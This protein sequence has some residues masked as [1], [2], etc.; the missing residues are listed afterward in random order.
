MF[1]LNKSCFSK[2]DTN[3]TCIQNDNPLDQF[4]EAEDMRQAI[5]IAKNI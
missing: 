4:G 5:K 1:M 3:A 2:H